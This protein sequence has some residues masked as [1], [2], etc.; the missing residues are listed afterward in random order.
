MDYKEEIQ[1]LK[2]HVLIIKIVLI[3]LFFIF[4]IGISIGIVNA[5]PNQQWLD[6]E[7]LENNYTYSQCQDFINSFESN[8][9]FQD[10]ISNETS[11]IREVEGEIYDDLDSRDEKFNE[12]FTLIFN[13]LDSLNNSSQSINDEGFDIPDFQEQ[14]EYN[15]QKTQAFQKC[16]IQQISAPSLD[17]ESIFQMGSSSEDPSVDKSQNISKEQFK[18]MFFNLVDEESFN[19]DE[20][21]EI[22]EI[23]SNYLTQNNLNSYKED[24]SSEFD[25]YFIWNILLT[26]GLLGS[27]LFNLSRRPSNVQPSHNYDL[28]EHKNT[29]SSKEVSKQSK[30]STKKK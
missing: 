19:F 26:L 16:K 18:E 23:P 10:T 2:R 11:L 24:V 5:T 25:I 14:L 3:F 15:R 4:F 8:I 12:T 30:K 17:C 7:C 22:F 6:D 27:L 21:E 13:E 20:D 28:N 29:P 1:D 9:T